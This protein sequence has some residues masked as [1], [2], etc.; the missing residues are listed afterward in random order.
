MARSRVS[1]PISLVSE[2]FDQP[3]S[4]ATRPCDSDSDLSDLGDGDEFAYEYEGEP[5]HCI[6]R[7]LPT[8][9]QWAD[10]PAILA[11]ARRIG[12]EADGC[13]KLIL[14]DELRHDAPV[15]P[16]RTLTSNGY[17]VT[18]IRKNRF[19]RVSTIPCEGVFNEADDGEG[20]TGSTTE[21]MN[22][23][24]TLFRKSSGRKFRNTR[25]RPD[26]PAWTAQQRHLAGVPETSPIHP[27]KG[28]LLDQTKVIV[29]GIHT[30]Y[31]YESAAHF[32]AMFQ[33]HAEDYRLLSLN[34]LYKGRKIWIVTPCTTISAVEAALGRGD[35]AC[36]QFMRHRAEFIFP[37]KLT[38]LGI[39]HRVVDQRPGETMVILPD[40]YHEGF[41]TGYT[42]AEAKNYADDG[43]DKALYAPCE[44]ACSWA[45]A[46]PAGH[47]AFLEA[48][49][50]RIDLRA[51]YELERKEYLDGEQLKRP[52]EGD[53]DNAEEQGSPE[54]RARVEADGVDVE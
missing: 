32:G 4:P 37:E 12:A 14:P 9:D 54:K 52:L 10:F 53:D 50:E 25:Y 19:W 16:A 31:V 1:S 26:V 13:F 2:V 40:A 8:K 28:D 15:K 42:L 17:K 34:H 39:D 41:S 21:A 29:P 36:S 30:P 48:G 46:I 27:L 3:K 49:E 43:W 20:F 33:I 23:L 18:Q 22:K 45:T 5:P 24:K 6:I 51:A 11:F 35:S 7:I 38:Q 44:E 47:M